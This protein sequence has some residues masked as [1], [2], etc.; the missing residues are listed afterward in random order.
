MDA[1]W[2]SVREERLLTVTYIIVSLL[3]ANIYYNV[4]SRRSTPQIVFIFHLQESEDERR[5]RLDEKI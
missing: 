2:W 3:K 5:A 1:R 4:I